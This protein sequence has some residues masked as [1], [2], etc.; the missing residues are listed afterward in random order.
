MVKRR[1]AMKDYSKYSYS[2]LYDMLDHINRY[3]Y[4]EKIQAIEKELKQKKED[5]EIPELIVP[6]ISWKDLKFWKRKMPK[7]GKKS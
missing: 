6:A 2:E 7:E 4:P 3:K 5:G 1:K